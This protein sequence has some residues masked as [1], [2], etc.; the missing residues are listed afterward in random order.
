LENCKLVTKRE[1]LRLHVS[2]GSKSGGYQS[3]KGEQVDAHNAMERS[4]TYVYS[5]TSTLCAFS[6]IGVKSV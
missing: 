5:V 3:E 6:Q 1:D 4:L 2:T